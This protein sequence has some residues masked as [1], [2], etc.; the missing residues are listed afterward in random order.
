MSQGKGH[1]RVLSKCYD[2]VANNFMIA[3]YFTTT[4]WA[5]AHPDLVRRF[6]EAIRETAVWANKNHAVSGEILVR[7]TKMAAEV[8]S[9][10]TR[11]VYPERSDPAQ[12]QPMI[13]VAAKY[14]LLSATFPASD[15]IYKP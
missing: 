6:A 14:G 12:M 7:E 8:A 15:L 10:M 2:G 11:S 1:L 4:T 5:K 9:A 13:D 3:A